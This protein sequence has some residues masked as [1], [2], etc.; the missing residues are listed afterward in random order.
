MNTW[1]TLAAGGLISLFTAELSDL[2]PWLARRVVKL[3]ARLLLDR[4]LAEQYGEEWLASI[5]STPG[6]LTPL[7]RATG[8]LFLTVPVLNYR[9]FD[10]WWVCTVFLPIATRV[11]RFQLQWPWGFDRGIDPALYSTRPDYNHL[12]KMT[13]AAVRSGAAE[14]RTDAL[15]ALKLLLSDPPPWTVRHYARTDLGH[16]QRLRSALARRGYLTSG[17]HG[18]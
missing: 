12:L 5:D 15:E 9:Y 2:G 1:Q 3:S 6:K 13:C 16:L 8:I 10:D 14:E 18:C 17:S 7:A 11:M 4:D